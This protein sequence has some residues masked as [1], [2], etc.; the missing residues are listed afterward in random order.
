MIDAG[1]E[2][3]VLEQLLGEEGLLQFLGEPA[4]AAPMIG[5]GAAAVGNDEAERREILEQSLLE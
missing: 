5:R 3:D 2:E 4:I 1:V